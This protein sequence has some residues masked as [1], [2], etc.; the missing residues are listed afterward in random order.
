MITEF[1]KKALPSNGVYCVAAIDPIKKI[2]RHKFVESIDDIQSAVSQ[3][4]EE[5]QNIFVAL[6]SFSSYSRKADDAVY[7]RSFFVDLDVGEGKGCL[8]YTSLS[9]RD[10]TRSRMPSSA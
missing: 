3:F 10:R 4:N 8:L 7:V 1:Y 9:P 5:K 6:S 2:P